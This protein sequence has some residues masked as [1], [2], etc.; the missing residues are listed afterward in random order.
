M[1]IPRAKSVGLLAG[2]AILLGTTAAHSMSAS[3][4]SLATHT[5]SGTPQSPGVLT[6]SFTNVVVQGACEVN[7]GQANVLDKLTID[8]GGVLLA[9]FALNDATGA[10]TS[11]LS[12]ADDIVIGAGGTLIMGCDPQSF[13]CLDDP[14]GQSPTLSSASHVGEDLIENAPLGVVVHNSTIGGNVQQVGGGGGTNC[15]PS[16][17][18]VSFGFPVFSAY[19]D[20]TIHG[21]VNISGVNSCWLGITR[22]KVGGS[23]RLSNNQLADP[24]A[25]E[26]LSNAIEVNLVCL[27]NSMVWDSS[28]V[29]MNTL[30]PR[31]PH[32]NAVEGTRKGQCVLSSP[33]T[34]GGPLGPGPF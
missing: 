14:N 1:H 15:T 2:L 6:G 32:P 24:D 4:G 33:T 10:G 21:N 9:A 16:G 13:P 18:F 11:G 19:E 20:S 22:S 12:V 28:E 31:T 5:C 25:I 3:A 7:Q 23:V 8:P 17:V 30:F 27:G 34:P 26:I 29:T